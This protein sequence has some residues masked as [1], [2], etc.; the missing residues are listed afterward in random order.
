VPD[1]LIALARQGIH[2]G[3]IGLGFLALD[4]DGL[5]FHAADAELGLE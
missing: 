1:L 4:E 5:I 3:Q 2:L